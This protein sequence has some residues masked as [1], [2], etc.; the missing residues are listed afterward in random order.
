MFNSIPP[1]LY[2]TWVIIAAVISIYVLIRSIRLKAHFAIKGTFI[3]FFFMLIIAA[4][5][6]SIASYFWHLSAYLEILGTFQ[7][8]LFMISLVMM[9][10]VAFRYGDKKRLWLTKFVLVF[11]ILF[12]GLYFYVTLFYKR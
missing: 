9:F 12:L 7:L 5:R 8:V 4:I 11:V 1:F 6:K 10:I 2:I 3:S